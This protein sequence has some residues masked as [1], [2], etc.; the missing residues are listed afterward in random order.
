MSNRRTLLLS[1]LAAL[2]AAVALIVPSGTTAPSAK[3]RL[4]PVVL[5]PAFHLTR[6]RV[7]VHNQKL[8]PACSRSGSFEDFFQNPHPGGRFSQVCRDKLMTLRY[9]ANPKLPMPRRFSNQPGVAVSV[10]DYGKTDSAPYYQPMYRALERAGYT[11]NVNIRV[12]GYDSRLTPDQGGFLHRARALI[13]QTY[14]SNG[15]QPVELV[16]HSNGP[17]YAQYLLTHTSRAWRHKYI[18]GFT[19]IAGNFPGQGSL[20]SYI[21]TGQN[22]E[23]FSYPRTRANAVSSARMYLTSPATYMSAADPAVFGHREVVLR[24]SSTGARYTPADYRRLFVDAHLPVARQIA[25][26]Y[27]GFVKFRTP[28]NFPYVDVTAEKG[29]GIPTIV[30]AVLPSLKVGQLVKPSALLQR[31]GDINQEHITNNAVGAWKAMPCFRFTLI[32]N[33]RV[34]HFALPINRKVLARLVANVQ[35]PRSR[36]G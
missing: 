16:G 29:S 8:D 9:N 1:P 35:R 30:G 32:D 22:I 19:P 11:A 12:A 20:Y 27:I 4:T 13:E 2:I 17:L 31:S 14:R 26:Y 28:R 18:H 5:F 15:D 36:C 10:V 33:P 3:P 23:N 24:N 7:T 25:D 6:L 34:N 21:F